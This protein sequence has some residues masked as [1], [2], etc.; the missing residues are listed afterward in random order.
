MDRFRQELRF[1]ARSL[2]R[3]PAFTAVA[4]LTLALGIGANTAIFS[5]VNAVLLRPLPV[6]EPSRLVTV[7]HFYPSLG[8]LEAGMAVPTFV[9]MGERARSFSGVATQTGWGVNAA[10]EGGGEPERLTGA[11]VTGGYFSTLG[12]PAAVGRALLP[13]DA[14]GDG[15][16]VVV[17]SDGLWR[18]RYG[19]DPGVVGRTLRLNGEAYEVVGVMPAG[20]RDLFGADAEL[21]GPLTFVPAQ[22]EARTSEFMSLVARLRPGVTPAEAGREMAAF[23]ER[24]KADNPGAYPAD[25]SLRTRGITEQLTGDLRPALMVLLGAVGFV[26]LIACANVANLLLARATARH[27]EVAVRAAL[28]AGRG[29]LVRQLLT[30][31][32]LLSL[33]GGVGAL[34]LAALGLKALAALQPDGIPRMDEVSIDGTVLLFTLAVAVLTGALFGLAPALK[35]SRAD[36]QS[37]LRQGGRGAVGDAGGRRVGRALIV[38]EFALALMLLVGAGLLLRSFARLTQVDPGFDPAN[39][40][41]AEVFL[42]PAQYPSDTARVAFLEALEARL[43]AV[44]GVRSVGAT[45]AIPFGGGETRS[46]NVEGFQPGPDQPDP[47]GDY[48]VV[49]PGYREAM[50]IPLL[51]GRFFTAADRM[52]APPVVVV[53]RDLAERYWPGADPIG[54]RVGFEA[55]DSIRWMEVVGVVEHTAVEGLDAERRVQLYRPSLQSGPG[56][57]V[58]AI[59]G[60]GDPERLTRAVRA[61]VRSLDP[62]LPLSQVR[63][64]DDRLAAAV[65]PR[66]F[67]MLLLAVFAGIAL[68]LAAVG[69]YGVISFDVTRR[70]QEMGVRMALG[71]ERGSVVRLV[72][73]QG[74]R[75]ALVGV[76]VGVAG[77]LAL[78]RLLRSQLY[79]VAA[80]D[81]VTFAVVIGLLLGI[82]AL[83][84]LLPARRATR[85]DPMVALR[86][87]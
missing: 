6:A 39:V 47:W 32:I 60:A 73:R 14:E 29:T 55:G 77:A 48:R 38:T 8:N 59:R 53:D 18:R 35:V 36:L 57:S 82:A 65:G 40:L 51:R 68:L 87:E 16:R 34:A 44:P 28:G 58:L 86:S 1:A 62:A 7:F 37:T 23:A 17:L 84:T 12:V 21:W 78:T 76:A 54:K 9:E 22:M 19:A 31:S 24:L 61:A 50:R 41:T 66:R 80:T 45:T 30:E 56:F 4:V 13:A 20:F 27:R 49:T 79:G 33:V 43:T 70:T 69:I 75:P 3:N 11:L 71:A 42:P 10:G 74:L 64:M 67:S 52:G 81:P 26:L 15:Q 83:A 46:F 2:A 25:W 5:V 72:L 63:T 85:V